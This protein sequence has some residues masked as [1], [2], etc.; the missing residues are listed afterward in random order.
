[1]VALELAAALEAL[2][3]HNEVHAI[4]LAADKR[5]IDELPALVAS[6]RLGL[7]TYLR[8]SWR[9]RRSLKAHPADL[10]LAHGGWAAIVTAFATPRPAVRVWQRI[11]GLPIDRWGRLR[12]AA[13]RIVARRFDGIV[14]LTADMEAEM[15]VLDYEGPVWLIANA[16]DPERFCGVNRPAA[17]A[18]LRAELG[19]PAAMPL[20]AFVGHLVDQKQPEVAV[21]VLAEVHRQGHPA[22]LVIAGDGPRRGAVECRVAELGLEGSV[23]LLGHRDDPELVFGGADIAL[24]TSRAEGIPGVAIE[25]Q[26]AGC[27]VV[28]YPVGAIEDVITDGLTGVI[29][30]RPDA[31][32]MAKHITGML[33]DRAHLLAMSRAAADLAAVFTTANTASLYAQTFAEVIAEVH[34]NDLPGDRRH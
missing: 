18:R 31:C 16:R 19:L 23:T 25:A 13:W 6:S 22:H 29:L 11:L 21:D 14:A 9:I 1:V 15:R 27:P 3:H 33:D 7:L 10:V 26:M 2:G 4:A 24:I 17:S 28:S 8:S 20:L 32:L 30:D 34:G 12:R 5:S